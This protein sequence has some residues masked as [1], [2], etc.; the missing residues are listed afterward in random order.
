MCL[1]KVACNYWLH[2]VLAKGNE[3]TTMFADR[4]ASGHKQPAG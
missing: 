1:H 3:S 4:S 2:C